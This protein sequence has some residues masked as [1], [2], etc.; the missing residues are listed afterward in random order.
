MTAWPA[1]NFAD[2]PGTRIGSL[3]YAGLFIVTVAIICAVPFARRCCCK[4]H[5]N[6]LGLLTVQAIGVGFAVSIFVHFIPCIWWTCDWGPSDGE[7]IRGGIWFILW[8]LISV[9]ICWRARSPE[10][11]QAKSLSAD[12]V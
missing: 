7:G 12:D 3:I 9:G 11:P 5:R 1:A 4:V 8:A 10:E 2:W 6:P